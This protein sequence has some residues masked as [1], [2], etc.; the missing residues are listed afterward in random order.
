MKRYTLS[1]NIQILLKHELFFD[2]FFTSYN[3][4]A[5]LA[6]KDMKAIGTMRKNRTLGTSN[7]IKSVKKMKKA[8]RE[9]FYFGSDGVVYF[10]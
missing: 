4:I 5:D 10:C 3:L 1:C 9:T 6:A 8:E 2:N 7:T